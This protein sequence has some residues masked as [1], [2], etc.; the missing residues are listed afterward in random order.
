MMSRDKGSVDAG[1]AG[2]IAM[3]E[4]DKDHVPALLGMS[5]AFT[6]EDAPNKVRIQR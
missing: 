1:M 2:F 4:D 6:L 3:L 5:T